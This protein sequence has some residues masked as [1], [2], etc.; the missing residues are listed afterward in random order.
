[1]Y[2]CDIMNFDGIDVFHS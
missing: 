1:M 2:N